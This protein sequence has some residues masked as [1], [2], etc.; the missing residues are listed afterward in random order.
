MQIT[1]AHVLTCLAE[2]CSYNCEDECCAP[3]IEVGADHP[4][5]DMFTTSR[6]R[7]TDGEPAISQCMV[8][9]CHFNS[10]RECSASGVTMTT[11]S[12]HADCATFR[13]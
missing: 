4:K 2:D 6:V 12:G 3:K 9:Q 8:D 11:H 7:V 1:E 10:S 13:V 5:C